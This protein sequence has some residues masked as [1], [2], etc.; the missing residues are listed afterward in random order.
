MPDAVEKLVGDRDPK[1]GD[2]LKSLEGTRTWDAVVD[3][4]G[5]VPRVVRAS[6]E[7]LAKRCGNCVYSRRAAAKSNPA[8]LR[9]EPRHSWA[10]PPRMMVGR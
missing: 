5:Q 10:S 4:S 2:G 8:M 3:F 6:A 9:P 7:L 1:L